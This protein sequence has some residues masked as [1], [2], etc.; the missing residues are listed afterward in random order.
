MWKET[1]LSPFYMVNEKGYVKRK[2]YTRVDKLGRKTL[3][4]EKILKP[5]ID[6]DGYARVMIVIG[7]EKPR[8]IQIHKLVANA[9]IDNP[10]NYTQINHKN[11][12][13][14]DNRVENLEWCTIAYNNNYGERNKKARN[15]LV[16]KYGKRIKAI[17]DNREYSFNSVGE[18]SRE[19]NLSSA[20]IFNC[21]SGLLRQTGGYKFEKIEEREVI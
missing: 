3:A 6:K 13:K 10:N 7:I 14:R 9:F 1:Y 19:L 17:K 16:K 20:N 12:I 21:L 18:A 2:S 11:E 8:F 5:Q 4:K 15:T